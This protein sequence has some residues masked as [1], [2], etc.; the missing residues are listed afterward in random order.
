MMVAETCEEV[1]ELRSTTSPSSV[2]IQG[3]TLREVIK[4]TAH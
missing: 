2:V 4:R 1:I 3:L